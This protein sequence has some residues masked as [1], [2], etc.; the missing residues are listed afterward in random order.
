MDHDGGSL[1]FGFVAHENLE[2]IV[3]VR[4]ILDIECFRTSVRRFMIRGRET[5]TYWTIA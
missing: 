5:P 2:P 3:P 4:E 1:R